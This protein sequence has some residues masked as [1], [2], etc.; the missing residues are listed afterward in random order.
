M[1]ALYSCVV[2]IPQ[3][4]FDITAD[5]VNDTLPNYTQPPFLFPNKTRLLLKTHTPN[6]NMIIY[7]YPIHPSIHT[8][9]QQLQ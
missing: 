9:T 7:I 5:Q 8:H 3:G 2:L 6:K 4:C 1:T